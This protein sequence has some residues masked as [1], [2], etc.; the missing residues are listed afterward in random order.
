M[1]D[2]RT[3]FILR[4]EPYYHKV[5]YAKVPRFDA[6]AAL[7]GVLSGAVVGYLALS[8]VGSGGIDLT[9][10]TTLV[11]YSGLVYWIWGTFG[12]LQARG[13]GVAGFGLVIELVCAVG[14]T[15]GSLGRCLSRWYR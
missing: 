10:L 9:D 14:P 3:W 1:G 6:G 8:S 15:L 13:V 2:Q 5:Q 4:R 7:L 12:F 11:W